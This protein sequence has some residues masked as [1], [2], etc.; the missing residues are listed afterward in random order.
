MTIVNNDMIIGIRA[1]TDTIKNGFISAIIHAII[2][3]NSVRL[4]LLLLPGFRYYE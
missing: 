4:W 2:I 3:A 1:M